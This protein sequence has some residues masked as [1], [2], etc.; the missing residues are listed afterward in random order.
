[1]VRG[2]R[3]NPVRVCRDAERLRETAEYPI[4]TAFL[5]ILPRHVQVEL[6]FGQ[7][8]T[9]ATLTTNATVAGKFEFKINYFRPV[10]S[11]F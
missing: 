1:M 7:G 2:C 11:K 9:E 8:P 3:V 10:P 5:R 4:E 6:G